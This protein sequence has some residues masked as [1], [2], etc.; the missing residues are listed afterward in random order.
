MPINY[1]AMLAAATRLISENG[2]DISFFT[3]AVGATTEY[4]PDTGTMVTVGGLP[5]ETTIKAVVLPYRD[6]D[7][8]L[9]DATILKEPKKV[10]I[11]GELGIDVGQQVSFLGQVYKVAYKS[12]IKP[13]NQVGVL[14]TLVVS[15]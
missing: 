5:V 11:A 15:S 1:D 8:F 2:G 3:P 4:D 7:A 14:T 12:L 13:N 6:G 9:Q 10:L